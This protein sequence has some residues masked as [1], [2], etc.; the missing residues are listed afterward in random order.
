VTL[1]IIF[2]SLIILF[3][4][5]LPVAFGFLVINVF[6]VYFLWGGERGL[7]QLI[8]SMFDSVTNFALLPFPL[9]VLMGEVLFQGGLAS[10]AI[11]AIDKWLGRVPGR[12]SLIAVGSG[13][14]LAALTGSSMASAAV[15][16]SMLIPEMEKHGYKK[17]MTLGP[18]LG[19]GCLAIMIPP[20]GLAVLTATLAKV[21]VGGVLLAGIIPGLIMGFLY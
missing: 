16:G 3:A 17:A 20:S 9:F 13:V 4:T 14:L 6:G 15:L 1:I 12:L 21:P 5:G 7:N 11:A 18:I 8:L 10:Q 19:S 2:G